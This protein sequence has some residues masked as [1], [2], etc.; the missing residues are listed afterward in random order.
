MRKIDLYIGD[1]EGL[2]KSPSK[3]EEYLTRLSTERQAKSEKIKPYESKCRSVGA[4]IL[5]DEALK[6]QGLREKDMIYRY[7]DVGKPCFENYPNLFFNLSH[8]G[9]RVMCV[10]GDVPVGCDIERIRKANGGIAKRFFSDKDNELLSGKKG[11]QEYRESFYTL[12]TL[13]ESYIK[14]IGLGIKC[15]MNCFSFVSDGKEYSIEGKPEYVF[16]T[17]I[18]RLFENEEE[19]K[20]IIDGYAYSVCI[21]TMETPDIRIRQLIL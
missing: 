8:S 3:F 9:S 15:P 5:L 12:W 6:E 16:R 7:G 20:K 21:N 2:L 19:S 13:K 11:E 10:M 4:G 14:C 1:I 18:E 17:G